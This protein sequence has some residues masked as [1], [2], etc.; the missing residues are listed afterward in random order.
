MN[1]ALAT[2]GDAGYGQERA[3]ARTK[4]VANET[5]LVV[6]EK[7]GI[8]GFMPKH[9][10]VLIPLKMIEVDKRAVKVVQWLNSHIETFTTWSCE[11]YDQVGKEDWYL[12]YVSFLCHHQASLDAIR[13]QV[14]QSKG[15][16]LKSDVETREMKSPMTVYQLFFDDRKALRD[17]SHS[18][19]RS[20]D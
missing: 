8:R 7:R 6:P 4:D 14:S 12:P 3:A 18:L 10:T 9:A 1:T 11:G 19:P 15:V 13:K 5:L 16:F 17:F 20:R 2:S